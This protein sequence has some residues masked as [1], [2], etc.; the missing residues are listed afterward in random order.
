MMNANILIVGSGAAGLNAALTLAKK[1]CG[2]LLVSESPSERAQSNMAEGGINAALDNCGEGDSPEL[3]AADTIKAGRNIASPAAVNGLC[4][5]APRIIEELSAMGMPFDRK[6]DGKVAQRAFGGQSRKR[7]C[8][9]GSETG[10]ILMHTLITQA[11]KYEAQGL[12]RRETGLLFLRVLTDDKGICGAMFA[13]KYTG[14]ICR[15][16]ARAVIMCTGGLNGLFG[17]ATGSVLNSGTAAASLFTSGVEFSNLEFIQFH[18]TTSPLKGK[19]MLISEAA[20]GEG[21]ILYTLENGQRIRFMQG[22][23]KGDLSPRDVIS[24]E[25]KKIIDKGGDIYLD[26]TALDGDIIDRRLG[27]LRESCKM[28]LGIDMKTAPLPVRPGI[29]YFM[30]G[31]RTDSSHRASIDGLFAAGEAACI[32]HGANRLGGNSLLG[33]LYGGECAAYAALSADREET[34]IT[35]TSESVDIYE[36]K[37]AALQDEDIRRQL[38]RLGVIRTPEVIADVQEKLSCIEEQAKEKEYLHS[39]CLLAMAIAESISQRRE[40]RGAHLRTDFPDTLPEY[41]KTSTVYYDGVIKHR[42]DEV[43]E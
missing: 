28:F 32:Y 40:S 11:R 30:G 34:E 18:P 21:G 33:A 23:E 26:L 27:S 14:K 12:I 39:R 1:G 41:R 19:S 5:A 24:I 16:T 29:H 25:E 10:L 4:N 35:A 22:F 37:A 31:V 15:I 20:R 38:C 36:V 8:Y 42:F 13:D 3:H 17:I 9:C 43:G 6:A 2:C 7:T